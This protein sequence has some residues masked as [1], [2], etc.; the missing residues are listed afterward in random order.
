M[1]RAWLNASLGCLLLSG[2]LRADP[3]AG[4]AL[5]SP[6]EDAGASAR[7]AGM[8]SA[9]VSVAD[10]SSAIFWNPGGLAKLSAPDL[11]IHHHSWLAG[12]N[13]EIASLGLPLGGAGNLALSMSY[14]DFGTFQGYDD[15]GTAQGTYSANRMGL[16]L[17]WGR[18]FFRGLGLGVGA[19]GQNQ[20]IAGESLS[21]FSGDLGLRWSP[22]KSLDLGLAYAGLGANNTASSLRV[23]AST[24]I[25]FD[26]ASSLLLALSGAWQPGGTNR[27]QAG[28][29]AKLYSTLA[30]RGGYQ[31]NFPDTEI[32]GLQGLS[33]GT[34][35]RVAGYQLDYAWQPYGEL[36]SSQRLSLSYVFAAKE[37]PAPQAKKKP[38]GRKPPH[39]ARKPGS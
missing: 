10:D 4:A 20:T 31:L 6:L 5:A 15:A 39:K 24:A 16:G 2:S 28:V 14:L 34:G 35:F 13:Q 1:R 3:L 38:A 7:A 19:K 11:A 30:L 22:F 9:F 26:S 18:E 33:V 25:D 8:G 32:T 17:A 12:T 36:G 27:I 29:E 37:S 23:G 21:S